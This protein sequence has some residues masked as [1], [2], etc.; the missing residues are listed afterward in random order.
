MHMPAQI[1]LKPVKM[2]EI[3]P[4]SDV[5]GTVTGVSAPAGSETFSTT[6]RSNRAHDTEMAPRMVTIDPD[7]EVRSPRSR[8]ATRNAENPV[9]NPEES[10]AGDDRGGAGSE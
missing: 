4:E 8:G 5:P 10:A 3:E 9:R 2:V 6:A 1:Q 7:A